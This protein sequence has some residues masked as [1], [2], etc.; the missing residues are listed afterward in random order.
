[1]RLRLGVGESILLQFMLVWIVINLPI[2][3][4][5]LTNR[6]HAFFYFVTAAEAL[7]FYVV[8]WKGTRK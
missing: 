1:V 6:I 8:I 7:Y 4:W 3:G 5:R 2:D